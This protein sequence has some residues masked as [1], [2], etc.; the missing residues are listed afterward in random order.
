M[1]VVAVVMG[2]RQCVVNAEEET[3]LPCEVLREEVVFFYG[4]LSV[5]EWEKKDTV[6]IFFVKIDI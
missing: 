5:E 4:G 3:R 1:V 6:A 2:R